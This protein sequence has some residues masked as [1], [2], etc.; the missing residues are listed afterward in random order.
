MQVVFDKQCIVWRTH[1]VCSK[2]MHSS[3]T[4][5]SFKH[6]RTHHRSRNDKL[7]ESNAQIPQ[8]IC[9]LTHYAAFKAMQVFTNHPECSNTIDCCRRQTGWFQ[10]RSA[11][12][13]SNKLNVPKAI[14][15]FQ[16]ALHCFSPQCAAF[17]QKQY[18]TVA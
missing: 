2:A 16:R 9:F 5:D 18:D 14:D 17:K 6:T 8:S 7:V 12:S 1:V 3:G 13:Q 15:C 10:Q 4:H 11:A